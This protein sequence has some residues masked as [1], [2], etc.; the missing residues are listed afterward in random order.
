V[1]LET[2]GFYGEIKPEMKLKEKILHLIEA[3]RK[4]V[5]RSR[6]AGLDLEQTDTQR[7]TS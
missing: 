5:D 6:K 2:K 3:T 7:E 1:P 4:V